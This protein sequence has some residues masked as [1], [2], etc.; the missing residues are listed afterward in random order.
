[1]ADW[2]GVDVANDTCSIDQ[3]ESKRFA[4]GWCS[5]HYNYWRGSGDPLRAEA[6]P[7]KQCADTGCTDARTA[8]EWC[9]KHYQR[10]RKHGDTALRPRKQVCAIEGCD[11]PRVGQGLCAKHYARQTRHGSP[12]AR[13]AGEVVDGKRICPGCKV[14]LPVEDYSPN[15][16][17]RCRRCI[18]GERRVARLT[19]ALPPLPAVH[20]IVC[21]ERFTP[22]TTR[23][24]CCS[25]ACTQS[26]KRDLDDYYR[27]T[28]PHLESGR[29][30]VAANP[31]RRVISEGRRRAAKRR[32]GTMRITREQIA[33]RMAY[34]GNRCWMCRGPFEQIDHVKPISKGGPHILANLRPACAACNQSKSNKW[35]GVTGALALAA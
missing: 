12:T 24:Y 1:M 13:V 20:C 10:W 6:E 26:R 31:D 22:R 16:T 21:S 34:F 7:G 3:C 11:K 4:R 30:W 17:G 29:R 15:S 28:N 19:E 2:L 5:K 14:D 32:S 35:D 33:S 18:A 27:R 8:R 9:V 23:N 25:D